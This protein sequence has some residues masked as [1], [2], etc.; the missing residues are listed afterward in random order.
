VYQSI[1]EKSYTLLK[2]EEKG[3]WKNGKK[4]GKGTIE[5]ASGNKYTGIWVNDEKTGQ[6][7][8]SWTCGNRYA[9]RCSQMTCHRHL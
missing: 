1:I 4:Y 7:V 6:G 3:E 2:N 8:F 5:Y 9:V